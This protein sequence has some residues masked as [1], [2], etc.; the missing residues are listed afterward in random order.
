MNQT[1]C[2]DSSFYVPDV[3]IYSPFE[4]SS[5][6]ALL[7]RQ[8]PKKL[9]PDE[10]IDLSFLQNII[11]CSLTEDEGVLKYLIKEGDALLSYQEPPKMGAVFHLRYEGRKIN[12][13]IVDKFRDRSEI[14]KV[15]LGKENY[16]DGINIALLSMKRKEIAWFKFQPKYHYYAQDMKELRTTCDGETMVKPDEPLYYKIEVLDYQNK[17]KLE[18]DDFIGRIQKMEEIRLNG[19]ELFQ[20]GNF[21]A[22]L[23]KYNTGLGIV[24]SFPKVLMDVLNEEQMEKFRYYHSIM[25]SNTIICKMKEKKWYEALRLCDDGLA[26]N[27]F[28]LKLLYQKGQINLHISNYDIAYKCFFQILEL[29]P[30]NKE[31]LEII[32]VAKQKQRNEEI[33]EKNKFKK[34]FDLLNK[35]ETIEIDEIKIRNKIKQLEN[36]R[37]GVAKKEETIE[38]EENKNDEEDVQENE[39]LLDIPFEYLEKGIVIDTE[40]PENI[41]NKISLAKSKK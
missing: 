25:H 9:I 40:D 28:D 8:I 12:G 3:F 34:V 29:D 39:D 19:K 20:N 38:I 2:P 18:N 23:K 1:E 30:L 15:K 10:Y 27:P 22:A 31:A 14:R 37:N 4:Q 35:E 26:V 11:P 5:E 13:E 41:F 16:I 32:E 7:T 6:P 33:A 24:K 17:E 36:Q 21:S